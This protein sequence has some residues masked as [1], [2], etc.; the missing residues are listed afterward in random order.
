MTP[1]AALLWAVLGQTTPDAR[2]RVNLTLDSCVPAPADE[3]RRMLGI[4]L[5]AALEDELEP[6]AHATR[7]R[8]GCRGSLAQLHVVDPITGKAL[9]RV[10][11]VLAL[12]PKAVARLLALAIT[13]LVAASWT[14]AE[15]NP[16]P[17]VP[18]AGPAPPPEAKQAV[19]EAVEQREVALTVRTWNLSAAVGARGGSAGPV[20]GGGLGVRF[21]ATD[22]GGLALDATAHYGVSGSP[23]GLISQGNLSLGLSAYAQYIA[24]RYALR[25]GVGARAGPVW[26]V[27]Q[28][29]SLDSASGSSL[30]GVWGGPMITA[31][32]SV[33]VHPAVAL[34]ASAEAGYV[35]RPVT[36]LVNGSPAASIEGAWGAVNLGVGWGI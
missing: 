23:L 6:S 22:W 17:A 21:N 28:P 8:V 2:P 5:H 12:A 24:A 36:A 30:F 14:E 16:T 4:E 26:L 7:V 32:L 31:S 9:D 15:T 10:I 3:V 19:R 18:P 27:G 1:A 35:V 25:A 11:D 33:P 29:Y 20:Y 13:E 34:E